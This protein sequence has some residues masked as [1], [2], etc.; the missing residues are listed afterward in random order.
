MRTALRVVCGLNAVFQVLIG[1]LCTVSPA[2]AAKVFELTQTGPSIS[3]IIRMFGGLLFGSGLAS[4]I[5]ARSPER[6][7]DLPLFLV[8][9]CIVNIS[10]DT[11]VVAN[12][13]MPFGN[14]AVGMILQIVI[15][16]LALGYV[17]TRRTV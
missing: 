16:V 5:V 4:A 10:A 9:A 15:I 11:M 2:V 14:L 17:R 8:A 13:D 1:L 6:N 3:A 7:P 12:G